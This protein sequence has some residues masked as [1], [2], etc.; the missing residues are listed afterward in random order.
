MMRLVCPN[1][2]AEYEVDD[3]AIPRA[4]RDVQCSNCGHGWFQAHPELVAEQAEEDALFGVAEDDHL[5]EPEDV[6]AGAEGKF[7]PDDVEPSDILEPDAVVLAPEDEREPVVVP[8]PAAAAMALADD[9]AP[10]ATRN[11]DDSI[12][13]VLREEAEREFS[14]R[15]A[16]APPPRL[17]TQTEMG[18]DAASDA[19][20]RRVARLEGAS[21]QKPEPETARPRRNLFPAI[22]EINSTLRASSGRGADGYDSV[23]TGSARDAAAARGGFGQGFLTLILLVVVVVA[24][25]VFAP[26]IGAKVPAL[27]EAAAG[28]V[29]AVDA[30]R[31]WIHTEMR[32]LIGM[33]RGLEGGAQG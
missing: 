6:L 22:E 14:A 17:E 21:E 9:A 26:L 24:L 11:I 8:E 25:Y 13:A 2:D 30:T 10:P 1:C 12:L 23:V 3:S 7:E 32:A 20:A 18:L 19:D 5:P 28:Y 4:G 16:E 33:L 31:R 29:S 15:R 27:A